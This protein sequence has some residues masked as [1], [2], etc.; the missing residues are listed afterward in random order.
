MALTVSPAAASQIS[1]TGI[2]ATNHATVKVP[3]A[4]ASGASAAKARKAQLPSDRDRR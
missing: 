3:A 1:G 2:G 4:P